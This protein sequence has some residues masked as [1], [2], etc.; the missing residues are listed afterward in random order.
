MNNFRVA[1]LQGFEN[2]QDVVSLGT[3]L[4]HTTRF[5]IDYLAHP[6][7]DSKLKQFY[8]VSTEKEL[9]DVLGCDF[10]YLS[11][12]DI[13][14]NEACMPF[15][16]GPRLEVS[17][18]ER[19]CPFGIRFR[20]GAYNSKFAVDEAIS[21]PLEKATSPKEILMHRWPQASWFDFSE[22]LNECFANKERVIIG[23]LW[24]GILGDSY[25]LCGFQNFLLNMSLNR[26]IVTTLVNRITDVYLELNDSIFS[27]LKGKLD[28]WF[29][30]NDFGSQESLLFSI[31][32][33]RD[34]FLY[35]I[36]RLTEHA[37]RYNIKV[38]MHSCGAISE[39]IPDLIKAGVDILDP[40]Q[41]SANGMAPAK[42]AKDFGGKIIFHGG[43][44]T[45][46]ILPKGTPNHVRQHCIEIIEI[47]GAAGGYI[48]APS[49][50]LGIDIPV[51]NIDS[52]YAVARS[53]KSNPNQGER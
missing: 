45:Q 28:I 4:Q 24:T 37:H 48:F 13:S 16:K 40:I 44:D 29:F 35:N 11:C 51:E 15:Y 21:G 2:K 25:R 34:I 1:T 10:Y 31:S 38:M 7:M 49:Q 22:M 12:R 47:L 43:I 46:H 36:T 6:G 50:I 14:Q 18:N 32:M 33:F 39:I 3:V 30:G 27:L 5:P 23:G 19:I 53:Y 26:D 41:V 8:G 9:L 52:M 20:R 42:L 17:D